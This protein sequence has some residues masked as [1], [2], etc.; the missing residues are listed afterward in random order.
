M[1]T[2]T[3]SVEIA[4]VRYS[5][6]DEFAVDGYDLDSPPIAVVGVG[7]SMPLSTLICE[8]NELLVG[9]SQEWVRAWQVAAI[10]PSNDRVQQR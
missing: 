7:D 5:H 9:T 10:P 2:A 3:Y 1:E 8:V 6:H 4:G